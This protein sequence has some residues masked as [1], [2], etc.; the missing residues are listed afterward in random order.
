ML[1]LNMNSKRQRRP[2][3]RLGEIGDISAAFACGFSQQ[4]RGNLG[5]K[6]YKTDFLSRSDTENNSGWGFADQ[7]ISEFVASEPGVSPRISTDLQNTENKNPN[8]KLGL[9]LVNSDDIDVVKSKFNFGT[10]SRKTRVMKRRGRSTLRNNNDFGSVWSSKLSPQFNNEDGKGFGMKEFEPFQSDGFND[11]Y[12]TN[13]FND[14]SG[15]E[16]PA[17]S[18][19]GWDCGIDEPAYDA[20]QLQ[21]FNA[22]LEEDVCYQQTNLSPM[23]GHV[24]DGMK[25][26]SDDINN[27]RRWLEDQGFGKYANVF[28][29]HEVDDEA[30]PLLTLED[31]KEIGVFAVGPR[32]K[33]YTAIQQLRRGDLSS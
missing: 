21:N 24:Y 14:F 23:S 22:L 6:R 1:V 33:L 5:Q 25:F 19:E 8:S 32:R 30:L 9:E 26:G 2:N 31:L 20:R 27:V 18:K 3:V 28:E 10:I 29:M 17:T 15:H 12:P 4:T 11:C 16:T 7:T 13:C